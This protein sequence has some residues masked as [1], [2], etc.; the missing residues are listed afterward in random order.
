MASFDRVTQA[1]WNTKRAEVTAI[2][3]EGLVKQ[4]PSDLGGEGW[5]VAAAD[6]AWHFA[7]AS[8]APK[9]TLQQQCKIWYLTEGRCIYKNYSCCGDVV[10]TVFSLLGLRDTRLLNRDDQNSDGIVTAQE[11][12]TKWSI[13]RNLAKMISGAKTL[14]SV[15]GYDGW[16]TKTD[17]PSVIP[18]LGDMPII[19]GSGGGGAEHTFVVVEWDPE[20]RIMTS[21]DGGQVD[22]GGQCVSVI[23]RQLVTNA[24]TGKLWFISPDKTN[25]ERVDVRLY[26]GRGIMGW[27]D[28]G[29][30][31]KFYVGDCYE[32]A[33]PADSH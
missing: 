5:G 9:A 26:G 22:A 32:A 33:R 14:G 30:L 28:V 15:V 16:V 18:L 27:I 6:I 19:G 1:I 31:S 20:T 25:E 11:A 3:L 23:K 21:V 4:K 10:H 29:S 12:R 24:K 8:M 2:A 7:G 17:N 13:G